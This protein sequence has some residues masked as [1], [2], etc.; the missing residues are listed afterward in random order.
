[1]SAGAVAA[2]RIQVLDDQSSPALVAT[3]KGQIDHLQ[4][5]IDSK[6]DVDEANQREET[7]TSVAA[8]GGNEGSADQCAADEGA[9]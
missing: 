1:M 5:L 4:Q 3:L 6:A 9:D 8:E 7:P 2:R